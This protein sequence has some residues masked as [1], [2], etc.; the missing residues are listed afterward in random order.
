MKNEVIFTLVHT[1]PSGKQRY[2]K[3]SLP[4]VKFPSDF[5]IEYN[6]NHIKENLLGKELKLFFHPKQK[7]Y[8]EYICISDANYGVERCV[9]PTFKLDENT[10]ISFSNA[11]AHGLFVH[12]VTQWVD[13]DRVDEDE[14]FYKYNT[15]KEDEIHLYKI[16]VYNEYE[17]KGIIK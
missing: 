12:D 11:H 3:S 1:T 15:I 17:F 2:Y 13:M 10:P 14:Y 8:I 9:F 6:I 16:A 5:N 4:L 7:D